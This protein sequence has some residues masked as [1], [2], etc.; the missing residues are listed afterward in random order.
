MVGV[1]SGSQHG[2][3]WTDTPLDIQLLILE[4]IP[5]A[6]LARLATLCKLMQAVYGE[7]L[8]ERE[9]C[10]QARMA[11]AWPAEVTE[12]LSAADTAVPRD[13]ITSSPVSLSL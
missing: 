13:L 6:Q 8:Q 5:L 10:I 12:G 7:R 1:L 9:T 2:L 4:Y 3:N 11:E